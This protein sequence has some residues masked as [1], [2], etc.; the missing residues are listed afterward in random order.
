M[1][2]LASGDNHFCEHLRFQE[3]IDVHA[4]MVEQAREVKADVFLDSGDI[5]DAASTPRERRA[6]AEWTTAMAE[7]CPVVF[8]KGNH[9]RPLDVELFRR[10]KTKHPVIVEE[11]ARVHHVAGAAIAVMAWPE[12][13]NLLAS[14]GDSSAVDAGMREALQSVL[15]GLGQHMVGHD[16]PRILLGHF[17]VDGS[18]TS[19][20]QP[21]LGMPINVSLSDLALAGAGLT[22]MGHIHRAQRFD[23]P[24]AG[25]AFYTGSPF[26]TDFGQ[27]EPKTI[28][29]AEFDGQRLVETREIETPCAP[30]VHVTADWCANDFAHDIP[31]NVAGAELR[32]QYSVP[33]DQR[34]AA[35]AKAT[36]W[37]ER[38]LTHGARDVKVEEVVI[39]TKRARAPEVARAVTVQ[40][41]L[42]AHWA[43]IGYE[44]DA[45]MAEALFTKASAVE[46][47]VRHAS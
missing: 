24:G 36:E 41:K 34:D 42:R 25:P 31:P 43:S 23:L 37:K 5:F 2:L 30:M 16:G 1:R 29:F 20:G 32:F 38:L 19:T 12:R 39:A 46:E 21:L 45:E 22:V 35:R 4:W 28:L 10:L 47:E 26:R 13:G 44:P 14:L 3:C 27:L 33:A 15:R 7:V 11:Q 6:V 8:A 40:D 17:M 18:V 9:D